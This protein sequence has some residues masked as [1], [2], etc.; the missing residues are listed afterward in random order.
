MKPT[1]QTSVGRRTQ[2]KVESNVRVLKPKKGRHSDKPIYLSGTYT[3][4][5]IVQDVSGFFYIK[6][7][8]GGRIHK[9]LQGRWNHYTVCESHLIAWLEKTD[10]RA[11]SRYPGAPERKQNRYTK[12]YLS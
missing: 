1:H 6:R 10:K 8:G 2:H 5:K 11:Q 4:Y 7:Y 9:D 12:E 3:E